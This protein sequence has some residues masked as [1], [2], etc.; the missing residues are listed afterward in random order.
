MLVK[1][2]QLGDTPQ[3]LA[4]FDNSA[5]KTIQTVYPIKNRKLKVYSII[6]IH[7]CLRVEE[8]KFLICE[9]AQIVDPQFK[10]HCNPKSDPIPISSPIPYQKLNM[11]KD[12]VEKSQ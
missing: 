2:H 3:P 7:Y 12:F 9:R 10:F 11:S 8:M 5:E 4:K 6:T 1:S